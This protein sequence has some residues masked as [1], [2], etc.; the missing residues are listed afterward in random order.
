MPLRMKNGCVRIERKKE[1]NNID[2]L[3]EGIKKASIESRDCI[4]NI[5]KQKNINRKYIIF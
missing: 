3:A 4:N 2:I 1:K 5:P